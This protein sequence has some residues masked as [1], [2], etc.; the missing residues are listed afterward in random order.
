VRETEIACTKKSNARRMARSKTGRLLAPVLALLAI[1]GVSA[2]ADKARTLAQLVATVATQG[3]PTITILPSASGASLQ[4]YS[5]ETA[6]LSLGQASY[7][8]G[9]TAPGVAAQKSKGSMILS[10]RF[11]MKVDCNGSPSPLADLTLSLFAVDPFLTVSMDGVKLSTTPSVTTIRCG[12]VTEHKLD[13]EIS[14]KRPA[15]PIGTTLS[16]SA[17][18][19]Y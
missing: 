17:K 16:F 18:P 7:Y 11:A 1:P 12:S 4:S 13:V 14:T 19:R 8:S 2:G 10:T 6:S 5:A 3:Q 15:G 9:R